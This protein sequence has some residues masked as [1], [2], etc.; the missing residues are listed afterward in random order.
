MTPLDA[1]QVLRAFV[2]DCE[3][4]G[5]LP[6]SLEQLSQNHGLDPRALKALFPNLLKLEQAFYLGLLKQ[7]LELLERDPAYTDYDL[8][9]RL[10]ALYYTLFEA[11]Q[12]HR[13]VLLLSL[14]AGLGLLQHLSKLERLKAAWIAHVENLLQPALPGFWPE[15]LKKIQA[16]GL[17]EAAWI[18]FLSVLGYWLRDNS[19]EQER[20]DVLIEKSVA[21]DFEFWNALHWRH[22]PDLLRFWLEE[23]KIGQHKR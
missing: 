4:R 2:A 15:P 20:S 14:K 11:L 9:E 1:E 7:T 16:R 17:S 6:E 10:L 12:Q 21:A 22:M 18:Q 13:Q 23:L 5:R 3:Q 19:P 8:P